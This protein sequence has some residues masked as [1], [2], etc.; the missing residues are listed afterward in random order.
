MIGFLT[1]SQMPALALEYDKLT[2]SCVH[3]HF[4]NYLAV[5]L[6]RI[7]LSV[8]ILIPTMVQNKLWIMTES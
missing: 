5:F 7:I 4:N 2:W 6:D 3:C 8:L 1:T